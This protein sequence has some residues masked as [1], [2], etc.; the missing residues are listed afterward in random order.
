MGVPSAGPLNGAYIDPADRTVEVTR[1]LRRLEAI[2]FGIINAV[3][4]QHTA[5]IVEG[6]VYEVHWDKGPKDN[7]LFEARPFKTWANG[8]WGDGI[9][10]VPAPY[11]QSHRANPEELESISPRTGWLCLSNHWI[12]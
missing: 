12:G 3:A 4:G 5:M 2:P 9:I 6:Y 1:K 10:H 8:R 11:W 7:D